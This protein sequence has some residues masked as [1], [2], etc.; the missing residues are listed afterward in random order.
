MQSNSETYIMQLPDGSIK[1]CLFPDG[2]NVNNRCTYFLFE[3]IPPLKRGD[4][5]YDETH[6]TLRGL[7]ILILD[8]AEDNFYTRSV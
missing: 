2:L 7:E 4:L 3:S 1:H 8:L 6:I 5:D